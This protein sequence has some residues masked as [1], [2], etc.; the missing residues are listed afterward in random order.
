VDVLGNARDRLTDEKNPP[1]TD[2]LQQI[3]KDIT[4]KAPPVIKPELDIETKPAN[5]A[6]NVEATLSHEISKPTL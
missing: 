5:V 3:Q 6:S 4:E 1:S 2:E